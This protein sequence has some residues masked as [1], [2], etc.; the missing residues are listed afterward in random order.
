MPPH[1]K[2]HGPSLAETWLPAEIREQNGYTQHEVPVYSLS[3][4]GEEIVAVPSVSQ[5]YRDASQIR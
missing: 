5:S 1:L 4:D 3:S 2:C